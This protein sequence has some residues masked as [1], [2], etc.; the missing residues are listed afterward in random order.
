M[1]IVDIYD[2]AICAE[3]DLEL[4]LHLDLVFN[5]EELNHYFNYHYDYEEDVLFINFEIDEGGAQLEI[6]GINS[7]VWE[8]YFNDILK[9]HIKN[10]KKNYKDY[11]NV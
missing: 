2:R 11:L 1:F 6:E 7:D 10:T 3:T 4:N 9:Q 5:E 8:Y